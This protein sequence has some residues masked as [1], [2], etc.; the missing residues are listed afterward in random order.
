MYGNVKCNFVIVVVCDPNSPEGSFF[1]D[2]FRSC[3]STLATLTGWTIFVFFALLGLDTLGGRGRFRR[4]CLVPRRRLCLVSRRRL[5]LV[6]RRRLGLVSRRRLGMVSRRRM[7]AIAVIIDVGTRVAAR[8]M[9]LIITD[10]IRRDVIV[11][12]IVGRSKRLVVCRNTAT[13]QQTEHSSDQCSKDAVHPMHFEAPCIMHTG[14]WPGK[15][16][17][18]MPRFGRWM[19]HMFKF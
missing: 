13:D 6:S 8:V 2:A 18:R 1:T 19:G 14:A 9:I 11:A 3:R 16:N 4:L 17:A 10:M 5:G 12:V 15:I 7:I